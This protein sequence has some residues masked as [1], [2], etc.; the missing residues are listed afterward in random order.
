ME[1]K[2]L[3]QPHLGK[4]EV[5]IAIT[6]SL[7]DGN[8][9]PDFPM[10]LEDVTYVFDCLKKF[11]GR[12][13]GCYDGYRDPVD[14]Y[15]RPFFVRVEEAYKGTDLEKFHCEVRSFLTAVRWD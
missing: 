3:D 11:M 1:R 15:Y 6:G 7:P 9:I 5:I 10:A 4:Q 12:M 14:E 8:E 2:Y 13:Y